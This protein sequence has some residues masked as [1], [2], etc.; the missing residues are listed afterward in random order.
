[1]NPQYRFVDSAL[2]GKVPSEILVFPDRVVFI[3]ED[4]FETQ[5]ASRNIVSVMN[6]TSPEDWLPDLVVVLYRDDEGRLDYF[7]WPIVD[8]GVCRRVS[9]EIYRIID[10]GFWKSL[11][12]FFYT[13]THR[14]HGV[15]WLY[16]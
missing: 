4:G 9:D 10:G 14:V 7:P 11:I 2:P 5:I 15:P 8:H 6:R 12:S 13:I 16:K 1:M 3:A